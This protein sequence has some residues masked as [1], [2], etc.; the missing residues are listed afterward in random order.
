M[1]RII[2]TARY[3]GY[4]EQLDGIVL[5]P[6]RIEEFD[7][8]SGLFKLDLANGRRRVE[9]LQAKSFV[10]ANELDQAIRAVFSNVDGTDSW[11]RITIER[12]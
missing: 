3:T 5:K 12:K 11:L 8:D 6:A 7:M 9:R 10:R 1:K 2:F 4:T